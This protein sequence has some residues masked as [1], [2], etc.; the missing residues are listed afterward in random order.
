MSIVERRPGEPRELQRILPRWLR[1]HKTGCP[2]HGLCLTLRER[3]TLMVSVGVAE[4]ATRAALVATPVDNLLTRGSCRQVGQARLTADTVG[5][6]RAATRLPE[7]R[8]RTPGV[9]W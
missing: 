1:R 5:L 3:G 7:K 4:T 2:V 6:W 9:G 8:M